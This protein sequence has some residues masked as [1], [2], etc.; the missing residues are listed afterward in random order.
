ML[1][2]FYK[3][4]NLI[5]SFGN[6]DAYVVV[7]L[8]LFIYENDKFSSGISGYHMYFFFQNVDNVDSMSMIKR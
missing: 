2:S 5:F 1:F 7:I 8:V 3:K 6:C 4:A